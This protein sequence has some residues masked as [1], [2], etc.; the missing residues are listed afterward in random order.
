[1]MGRVSL[2]SSFGAGASADCAAE[3][4]GSEDSDGAAAGLLDWHPATV[5]AST[6]TAMKK[7][8]RSTR[9]L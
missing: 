9:P 3:S 2:G 1:M 4:G 6:G 7:W 5:S 8:R